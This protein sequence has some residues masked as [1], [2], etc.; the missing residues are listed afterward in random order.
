MTKVLGI[1]SASYSGTTTM[2]MLLGALPGWFPAGE[3]HW[4]RDK[5]L[6]Q[7][8]CPEC[9]G[10]CRE[11]TDELR[12][13]L[14]QT[15][16]WW[17]TMRAGLAQHDWLVASDKTP[18]FYEKNP[19]VDRYLLQ[20]KDPR[21]WFYSARRHD[22]ITLPRA[23]NAWPRLYE[24]ALRLIADD[25]PVTVVD[26]DRFAQ[27]PLAGF[28]RILLDLGM[29]PV[30]EL[31]ARNSAHMLGGNSEA[32]GLRRSDEHKKTFGD[33]IQPDIRWQTGN[34]QE[35]NDTMISAERVQTVLARLADLEGGDVK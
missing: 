16:N 14:R 26:W 27:A 4:L 8:S 24:R 17:S 19:G 5:P 29:E 12:L 32:R 15:D 13:E 9:Q 30:T 34:T 33:V 2:T 21:G 3:T 20:W 7:F 18:G 22:R 31:P 23:V 28:N 1:V 35:E 25:I 6:D 11:W 10:S